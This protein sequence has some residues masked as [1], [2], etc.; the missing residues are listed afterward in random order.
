MK[1]FKETPLVIFGTDPNEF[2]RRWIAYTETYL[3]TIRDYIP[4]SKS[5]SSF[6]ILAYSTGIVARRFTFSSNMRRALCS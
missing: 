6:S 4:S 3:Y 2:E 1:R 5:N